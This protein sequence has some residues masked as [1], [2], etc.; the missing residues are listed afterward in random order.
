[1][2]RAM[3]AQKPGKSKQDY[4]TPWELIRAVEARWGKLALDLAAHDN[5]D[6]AKAPA[7]IGESDDYL[8]QDWTV[9]KGLF[10]TGLPLSLLCWCNPPFENLGPWAAKW[11][12]DAKKG[13]RIIALVPASIGAEWF[14]EHVYRKALVVA[15]RPRLTFEGC[16]DPYPKDCMLLCYGCSSEVNGWSPAEGF[17]VW[18]WK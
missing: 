14:A 18:R 1:M 8:K 10:R 2:S 3:P 16:S 11:A 9:G 5:G 7:W 6:N 17:Q 12:A 15:L 13:A 4:G